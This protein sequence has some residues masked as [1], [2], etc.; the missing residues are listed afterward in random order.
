MVSTIRVAVVTGGAGDIGQAIA[1]KLANSHEAVIIVDFDEKRLETTLARLQQSGSDGKKFVSKVCDVTNADEVKLLPETVRSIGS[2][3]TLVNNAGRT[4]VGSLHD[5]TAEAWRMEVSLNL[6]AAFIC[7]SAFAQDMKACGD[8]ASVI[9]ISSVNG[10]GLYGNPAYSA[11]KA[12]L[13][14]FTK[15]I[16]VEYGK[17]GIRANTVAP[18]TVRTAAWVEKSKVNATVLDEVKT[19][20]PLGHIAEPGDIANA[21]AF[22]ASEQASCIT[23]VCLPVD[24]GLTAGPPPL[25]RAFSVSDHY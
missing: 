10:L 18:G 24:C 1:I 21:V 20:Y 16:A 15:S 11:A 8:G 14:H 6:D 13:I 25:A 17:F 5:M 22:L 7:F 23:G 19:W 12:G 4:R 3:K 9:N 2:I